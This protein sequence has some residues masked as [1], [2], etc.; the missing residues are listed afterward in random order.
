MSVVDGYIQPAALSYDA[1][2]FQK[3]GICQFADVSEHGTGINKIVN[4]FRHSLPTDGLEKQE[5]HQD[6]QNFPF[7]CSVSE[8][9]KKKHHFYK[10]C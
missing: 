5:A 7:Y 1:S 3:P 8:Y 4:P 10:G 9:D 6:L 2:Q